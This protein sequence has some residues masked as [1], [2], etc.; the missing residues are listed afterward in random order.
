MNKC[1]DTDPSFRAIYT[2]NASGHLCIYKHDN[3][4][5]ILTLASTLPIVNYKYK[6]T[7]SLPSSSSSAP[8]LNNFHLHSDK[9]LLVLDENPLTFNGSIIKTNI[10]TGTTEEIYAIPKDDY[11]LNIDASYP[12]RQYTYGTNTEYKNDDNK[13]VAINYS[14]IM[15]LDIHNKQIISNKIYQS[16]PGFTSV[17]TDSKGNTIIG[18]KNGYVRLFADINK[19]AVRV[20]SIKSCE[21]YDTADNN[22]VNSIIISKDDKL[23]VVVFNSYFILLKDFTMFGDDEYIDYVKCFIDHKILKHLEIDTNNVIIKCAEFD[24]DEWI[25][26]N[27]NN[28]H[29]RWRIKDMFNNKQ[30]FLVHEHNTDIRSHKNSSSRID[31]YSVITDINNKVSLI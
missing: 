24:D 14:Q 28:Y 12:V 18:D 11:G 21:C 10:H 6:D 1:I 2:N 3:V 8:M 25:S 22:N 15:M 7:T 20:F 13:I 30:S 16:C 23:V 17:V 19:K 31:T 5:D 26:F 29:F 27:I 4:N 9:H